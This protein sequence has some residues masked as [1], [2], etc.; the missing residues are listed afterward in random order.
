MLA[1]VKILNDQGNWTEVENNRFDSWSINAR[2]S[3]VG[4]LEFKC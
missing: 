1:T 2:A 3:R 4:G